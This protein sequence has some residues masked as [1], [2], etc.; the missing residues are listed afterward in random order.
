MLPEKLASMVSARD[1]LA[2]AAV[3]KPRVIVRVRGKAFHYCCAI[4]FVAVAAPSL[5]QLMHNR[6]TGTGPVAVPSLDDEKEAEFDW[7][8]EL[9]VSERARRAVEF[10]RTAMDKYGNVGQPLWPVV[11][12]SL[13]GAFLAGEERNAR[14]HEPGVE[15]VGAAGPQWTC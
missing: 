14:I 6:E 7:D 10:M 1:E 2:A 9:R 12:S 3:S 13:Y 8:R 15:V 11:P 4:P 5:S